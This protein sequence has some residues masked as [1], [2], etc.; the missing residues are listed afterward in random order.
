MVVH[1]G[2]VILALGIVTSTTYVH[3]FEVTLA[4]NQSTVVDGQIV[5]FSGFHNVSDALETAT[6][7][8]VNVEDIVCGPR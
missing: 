7:L 3:R 5:T 2:V 8:A 4:R 1:L 6:Q